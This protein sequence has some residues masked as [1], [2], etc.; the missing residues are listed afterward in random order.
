MRSLFFSFFV[1]VPSLSACRTTDDSHPAKQ[2]EPT[3]AQN[4]GEAGKTVLLKKV[5][6]ELTK[7]YPENRYSECV[8]YREDSKDSDTILKD[9]EE[10]KTQ[11]L[12]EGFIF[13][14]QIPSVQLY[15]FLDKDPILLQEIGAEKAQYRMPADATVPGNPRLGLITKTIQEKCGDAQ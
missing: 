7:N 2:E 4:A 13:R 5:V 1:L 8:I 14:P 10:L 11:R 3:P 15:G 12:Q 6:G 9:L